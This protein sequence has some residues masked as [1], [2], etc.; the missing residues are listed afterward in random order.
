MTA[1]LPPPVSALET[2]LRLNAGDLTGPDAAAA[3]QYLADATA[4][5]LDE[6]PAAT[7][8][9]WYTACPDVVALIIV[10]AAR[11]EFENPSGLSQ[12]ISG[13]HTITT[14]ATTGVFLTPLEIAK[15]RR[16]AGLSRSGQIGTAVL[17]RVREWDEP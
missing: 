5:V 3:A 7:Q 2:R 14:S 9:I 4:L 8:S 17:C 16:A 1:T 13:E 10:K 15:V 6:V 11:R 12:E